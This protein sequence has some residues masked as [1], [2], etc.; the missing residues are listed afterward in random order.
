M[1]FYNEQHR[2]IQRTA[3]RIVQDHINPHVDQW[4]EAEIFPAKALFKT[5]GDAGL[6]GISKPESV[7]GLGL[8]YS[9][10]CAF[11]EVLGEIHCLGVPTAIGVQTDMATPALAKHGSDELHRNYLTPAIAGDLVACIGVSEP[12]AGSDVAGIKTY[13]R[14]DGDDL[15]INGSKTWITNGIQAD[16]MTAL[17]NTGDGPVHSNKSLVVIPLDSKGVDRSRKLKK[18]G[19]HSSDTGLLFFEDVRVPARNIIGEEGRGFVYQM[20]QFQEERLWIATSGV[21]VLEQMIEDTIHYTR[22]RKAFGK[23]LLHNQSIYF[24]LAELQTDVAMFRAFLEQAIERYV[25]GHDVTTDVSMLKLKLGRLQRM[26][27][28]SC[29]Q[30][31]GGMGLVDETLISRR[32]RDQRYISIVGGA[33]EVMLE[34]IAKNIG[35]SPK[36]K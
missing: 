26:V 36:S 8:D 15:I 7:G 33:D 19:V 29:L 10:Q 18:M 32:F 1:R 2:E 35:I 28:D 9:Y 34:I 13:A 5:L 14:R 22:E 12:G 24:R 17:V 23:P 11:V 3:R 31:W 4:E 6:L 27:S 30:Y 16:F 25:E 21:R 20:Q